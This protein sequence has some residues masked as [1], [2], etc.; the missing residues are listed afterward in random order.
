MTAA[1]ALL[2]PAAP[3][4]QLIEVETAA[5]FDDEVATFE[6]HPQHLP[7]LADADSPHHSS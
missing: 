3:V 4:R 6:A 5:A 2:V 1:F 7:D